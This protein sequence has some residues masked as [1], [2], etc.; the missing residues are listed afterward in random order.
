VLE[1]LSRCGGPAG[2]RKAGLAKLTEIVTPWAPRMGVRLVEQIF[3]ALDAQTVVVPGTIA[4]ETI[5]PRLAAAWYATTKPG[6]TTP[7]A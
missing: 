6:P 3:T 7:P 4:A 1:L 5:L 2:L